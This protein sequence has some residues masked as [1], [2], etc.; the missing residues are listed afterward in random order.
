ML[1]AVKSLAL[2]GY[3][4]LADDKYMSLV[5]RDVPTIEETIERRYRSGKPLT[6]I[7][8]YRGL[9]LRSV[10]LI[11]IFIWACSETEVMA[12]AFMSTLSRAPA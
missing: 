1:F 10:V 2:T 6:R 5:R 12:F 8:S 9:G 7:R 11:A 4:V 3:R